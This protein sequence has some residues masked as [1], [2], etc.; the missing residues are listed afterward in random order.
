MQRAEM[1]DTPQ[2]PDFEWNTSPIKAKAPA[3]PADDAGEEEGEEEE[4]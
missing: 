1:D 3:P 2:Y 4:E